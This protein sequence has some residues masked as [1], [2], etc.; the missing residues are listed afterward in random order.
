MLK[1]GVL[2][3][4]VLATCFACEVQAAKEQVRVLPESKEFLVTAKK[5]QDGNFEFQIQRDLRKLRY[6][7]PSAT[8]Y[9]NGSDGLF[10][11]CGVHGDVHGQFVTYRFVV[12]PTCCEHSQF[13]FLELQKTTSKQSEEELIGGGSIY[14]FHLRD[15]I[16]K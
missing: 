2:I 5:R 9:V 3:A 8:L 12:S 4:V 7:G 11:K 13:M 1:R 14:E 10:A 6:P 16:P 15:F